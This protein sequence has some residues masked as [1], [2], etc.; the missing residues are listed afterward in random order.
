MTLSL[1][2]AWEVALVWLSRPW[3][4]QRLQAKL[5]CHFSFSLGCLMLYSNEDQVIDLWQKY[6]RSDDTFFSLHLITCHV[7]SICS[8]ISGV[9]FDNLINLISARPLYCKFNLVFFSIL[10]HFKKVILDLQQIYII[11]QSHVS[12]SHFPLM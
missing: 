9:H 7:I 3:H 2:W 1:P 8:V 5:F 10:W 11:G 12:V 4:D 6:Y